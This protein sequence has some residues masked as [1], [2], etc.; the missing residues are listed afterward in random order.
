MS[1][2]KILIV[3]DEFII[4]DVLANILKLAGYT[5]CG[6]ADSVKEALEMLTRV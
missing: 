6:I 1:K 5:V 2:K 4:A 3:E